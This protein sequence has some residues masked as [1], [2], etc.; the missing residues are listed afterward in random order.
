MN[1]KKTNNYSPLSAMF[2]TVTAKEIIIVVVVVVV[3]I[4][5]NY[6]VSST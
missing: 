6:T 1:N 5:C 2:V 3:I 4:N